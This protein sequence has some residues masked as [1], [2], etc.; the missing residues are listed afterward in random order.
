MEL[1]LNIGLLLSLL[2]VKQLNNLISLELSVFSL[3]KSN[4]LYNATS[5]HV[6]IETINFLVHSVFEL[7]LFLV[8]LNTKLNI[9]QIM[10]ITD[11]I[12]YIFNV[13]NFNLVI[14]FKFIEDLIQFTWLRSYVNQILLAHAYQYIMEIILCIVAI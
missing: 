4:Y 11:V 7:V 13:I 8:Q 12:D 14:L 3:D 9:L 2:F 5:I 6:S 1:F 10:D